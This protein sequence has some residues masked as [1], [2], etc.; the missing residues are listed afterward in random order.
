MLATLKISLNPQIMKKKLLYAVI[1]V[2]M[3]GCFQSCEKESDSTVT[4]QC[5]AIT[6]QGTQCKRNAEKGGIYCWQHK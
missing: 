4:T 6:Q 1:G 5:K 3:L 2:M